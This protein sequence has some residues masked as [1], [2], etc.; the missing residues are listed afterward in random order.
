MLEGGRIIKKGKYEEFCVVA[1]KEQLGV[2]DEKLE[3]ED[4]EK[5]EINLIIEED[6]E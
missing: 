5:Q 1:K 3:Y 6:R 4:I 2:D